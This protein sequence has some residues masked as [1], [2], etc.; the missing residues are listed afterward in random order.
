[1]SVCVFNQPHHIGQVRDEMLKILGQEMLTFLAIISHWLGS[2]SNCIGQVQSINRFTL[3][4]W[5]LDVDGV[6]SC[7]QLH[8]LLS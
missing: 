4:E 1:M 2:G 3:K 6:N 5:R 7:E 8:S